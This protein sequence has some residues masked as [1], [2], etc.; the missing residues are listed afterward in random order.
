M[1]GTRIWSL[2]R[3]RFPHTQW[4]SQN[5]ERKKSHPEKETE[6]GAKRLKCARKCACVCL[7][8]AL[9]W[10]EPCSHTAWR[11]ILYLP[12]QCSMTTDQLIESSYPIGLPRWWNEVIQ[13]RA[14]S[15]W[16]TLSLKRPRLSLGCCGLL[17][18]NTPFPPIP[19]ACVRRKEV[20]D[21]EGRD[22]ALRSS[23]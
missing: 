7:C 16:Q 17:P 4:S 15:T 21:E 12:A 14:C 3:T 18:Q 8:W 11:W 20:K 6:R 13:A 5:K 2:V 10:H 19:L 22:K 9:L 23:L 1:Q